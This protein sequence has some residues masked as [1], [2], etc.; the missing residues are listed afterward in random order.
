MALGDDIRSLRDRI[1]AELNAAYDYYT[2]TKSAWELVAEYI[3]IGKSF[4]VKNL[5]TGTE[6]TPTTLINRALGY[7]VNHLPEATFQQFIALFEHFFFELL[8]LWLRS[9]P[10]SLLR[11]QLEFKDVLDS[12]DK[13][14]IIR[15]VVDKQLIDI[16]YKRPAEWFEYLEGL[17]KL[18]C[19]SA[20]E[21]EY[22]TEAKASRDVLV[23]NQGIANKTYVTK[24]GKI[25]RYRE[26]EKIDVPEAYHRRTWEMIRKMVAEIADAASAKAP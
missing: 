13:D 5:A 7:V 18:D 10:Q 25:A 21:I 2:D 23:H 22:I 9:F 1:L 17:V 19:P 3:T 8:R 14:G 15:L 6:T 20:D 26:G 11:K 16:P 12:P 24:A 4:G